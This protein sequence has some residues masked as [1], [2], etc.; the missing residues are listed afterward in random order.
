MTAH[1]VNCMVQERELSKKQRRYRRAAAPA[2]A[3]KNTHWGG[4]EEQ[5]NKWGMVT[6]SR[7]VSY[8]VTPSTTDSMDAT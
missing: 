4:E 3:R 6:P 1:V 8:T 5:T 7:R 2:V